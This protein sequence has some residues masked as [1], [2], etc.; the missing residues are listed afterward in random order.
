MA[1]TLRSTSGR[2][3][4]SV[5]TRSVGQTSAA[6]RKNVLAQKPIRPLPKII[7]NNQDLTP[8]RLIDPEQYFVRVKDSILTHDTSTTV[9]SHEI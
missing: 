9:S 7:E 6:Q 8:K 5:A 4:V 1:S 2:T 3:G